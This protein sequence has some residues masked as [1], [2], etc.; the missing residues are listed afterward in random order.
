MAYADLAFYTD[1]FQGEAIDDTELTVLL[2]RASR[3][4][5][6]ATYYRIGQVAWDEW[7]AFT[8]KQIKLACCAEAAALFDLEQGEGVLEIVGSYSIG[9][10][11]VS[12]KAEPDDPTRTLAEH[13]ALSTEALGLLM[14]TGL[15]DR[16]V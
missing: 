4:I 14:P 6:R 16:R 12:A 5:D 8:Q 9:D 15:L 7:P 1:E 13:Y 2:E 10:V 3:A 11:S